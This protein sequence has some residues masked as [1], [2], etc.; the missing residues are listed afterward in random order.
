MTAAPKSTGLR[1]VEL[2]T[3]CLTGRPT[4]QDSAF[5]AREEGGTCSSR[6]TRGGGAYAVSARA[7]RVRSS[8]SG[9]SD[10]A[11]SPIAMAAALPNIDRARSTRPRTGRGVREVQTQS[12]RQ[13]EPSRAEPVRSRRGEGATDRVPPCCSRCRMHA[14][15]APIPAPAQME[16]PLL[17]RMHKYLRVYVLVTGLQSICSGGVHP[18]PGEAEPTGEPLRT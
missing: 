13:A 5:V 18:A 11:R 16:G 6:C 14:C 2:A 17:V 1:L 4:G 12:A 15:T 9:P 7:A 10:C 8:H 3:P